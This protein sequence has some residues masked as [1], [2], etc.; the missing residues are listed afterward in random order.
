MPSGSFLGN[1]L[2]QD[3][4]TLVTRAGEDV[5]SHVCVTFITSL[6]GDRGSAKLHQVGG[7][8]QLAASGVDVAAPRTAN[9]RGNTSTDEDLLEGKHLFFFRGA[10]W[11]FGSRIEGDQVNLRAK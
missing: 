4:C 9:K 8:F 1:S 10:I 2:S 5:N 11:D 6:G 7:S 3:G